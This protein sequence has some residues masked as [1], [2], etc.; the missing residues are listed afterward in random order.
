MSE[1]EKSLSEK[2]AQLPADLQDKFVDQIT[3]AVMAI[4]LMESNKEEAEK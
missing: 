4:E 3:G 2:V 1:K